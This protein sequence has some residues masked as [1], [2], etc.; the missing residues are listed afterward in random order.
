[1]LT[2]TVKLEHKIEDR[3]YTLI[4]N[5]DSPFAHVKDALCQFMAHCTNMENNIKSQQEQQAQ[6]AASQATTDTPVP[7]EAVA[8]QNVKE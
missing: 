4:V 3:M 7:V 6:Q 1:M 8:E 5:A 2:N